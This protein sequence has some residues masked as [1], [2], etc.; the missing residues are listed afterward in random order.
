M[1]AGSPE[2][3]GWPSWYPAGNR[4]CRSAAMPEASRSSPTK[5]RSGWLHTLR[6]AMMH[7][8]A[9]LSLPLPVDVS[10]DVTMLERISCL[11]IATCVHQ[12]MSSTYRLL[13][14]FS[15][16]YLKCISMTTLRQLHAERMGPCTTHLQRGWPAKSDIGVQW[17]QVGDI[18]F[19]G[20]AQHEGIHATLQL[21]RA[22][23]PQGH[24]FWCGSPV[25]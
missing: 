1:Q 25:A 16:S 17:G 20:A 2:C 18:D 12:A 21:G 8:S 5:S 7:A 24:L 9:L 13:V 23:L 4:G 11:Y 6:M 22:L 3:C 14:L 10:R 19:L 15:I